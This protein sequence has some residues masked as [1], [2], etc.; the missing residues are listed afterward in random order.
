MRRIIAAAAAVAAF[1]IVP[2]AGTTGAAANPWAPT[3]TQAIPLANATNLGP[4]A[5]ST[6]LRI[7]VALALR[8]QSRLQR[9]IAE[10]GN[11]SSPKFGVS[12]TPAQFMA[13]Y[14]P[15]NTQVSW[16]KRYLGSKGFS[17]FTVSGNRIYVS[18]TGTAAQAESAFNT[19]IDSFRQN[20]RTVYANVQPAMVP[21]YTRQFIIAVLGLNNA[22][23]MVL[24]HNTSAS[25]TP[26]NPAS[27]W[28]PGFQKAY[29]ATG[30]PK[31]SKTA[32]A[33]FAEGDL[34]TVVSDLRTYEKD[35]K[36]NGGGLP[37]VPVTVVRTGM[38]SGDTAGQTEWDMD[39]Q[40]STGLAGNVK[41]L[42]LY[43]ATSLTDSDVALEFAKF[44]SQ[45]KAKAGSAS[46]GECEYAPY[47][48]GFMVSNDQVMAEAAA[49]GQTV[50]ASSGDSGGFCAVSGL[51][52]GAPAGEPFVNY[53]ASSPYVTAVGGT[54]LF[55]QNGSWN[56]ETAWDSGGGGI[57]YFE[58]Q[59]AWQNGVA[60]PTSN[61]CL[62]QAP[63][64]L[65]RDLPDVAMDADFLVSA[66]NFYDGGAPTS[67]GGTSLSSPLALGS[68]ARIESAHNNRIGY[69]A[70]RLYAMAGT[71]AFNTIT[72][73]DCGP[74]PA[75]PG[76]NYCTGN[77]SFDI[78]QASARITA[79]PPKVTFQPVPRPACNLFFGRGQANPVV[80][81]GNDD[82]LAIEAGGI[83]T[84][85]A[86]G[87][88]TGVLRVKSLN[89]GPGGTTEISGTGDQW[90]MI[91]D[92]QGQTFFFSATYDANTLP[93]FAFNYGHITK[94]GGSSN[95][96]NDG[97]ATGSVD[98]AHG[99]ISVTVPLKSFGGQIS[100]PLPTPTNGKLLQ[101]VGGQ[102]FEEIGSSGAAASLQGASSA[103]G[104]S[105]A[106]GHNC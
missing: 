5:G 50:F 16:V 56:M 52:N 11:A 99:L 9:Y 67:N 21:A 38:A 84:D 7:S 26:D 27:Y 72:P 73:S 82:A 81:N 32:I 42:Y 71:S 2:F 90:Y 65:G 55:T 4:L 78:K 98:T 19:S 51:A 85:K 94:I 25:S 31:G 48:D 37:K 102:T 54:T 64:C 41:R 91:F 22:L 68:W 92:W 76:W 77:G 15:T 88:V 57:S 61:S 105:Y 13:R 53:P 10:I 66:A 34:S 69:A 43:D 59:P 1:S 14:G 104:G 63:A 29:G 46:F 45:D 60:P 17:H 58:Y 8:N 96:Q 93:G 79:S 39:T 100:P 83:S 3:A 97:S 106:V 49:Q 6:P 95:Y 12:L 18:A 86:K 87:T 33:I 80:S 20:G 23:R 30:T 44:A 35:A 101:R 75:T 89:D 74:Y 28:A 24:P 40:T 70:P 47:L 62:V 103:T 36:N